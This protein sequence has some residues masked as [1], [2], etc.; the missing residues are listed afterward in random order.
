ME[1]F[2]G[3]TSRNSLLESLREQPRNRGLQDPF[4]VFT[5]ALLPPAAL[6]CYRLSFCGCRNGMNLRA[7]SSS[8]GFPY[9]P[10][11]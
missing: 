3:C 9:R 7:K 6:Y 8:H 10:L 2:A 1:A 5:R 4:P 11:L